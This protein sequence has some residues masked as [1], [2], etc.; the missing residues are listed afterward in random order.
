MPPKGGN[1]KKESG[2][3]KKA[4]NDKKQKEVAAA[5]KVKNYALSFGRM[6]KSTRSRE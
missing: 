1:A 6:L 4:E 3:A 5:E 2:R